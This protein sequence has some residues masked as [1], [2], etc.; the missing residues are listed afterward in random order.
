MLRP[1]AAAATGRPTEELY[2]RAGPLV[3]CERC[4]LVRQDP[5]ARVPYGDAEDPHYLTEIDGLRVTFRRTLSTIERFRLPPGRFLDVG[6]GPGVLVEE[7]A[8]RGWDAFGVELSAWSVNEAQ[9]RGTDVRMRT[10]EDLNE[11]AGSIDAAT[12]TD[13]IEHLPDPLGT[14][15]LLHELLK[16]GGVVFLA[17][18]DVGSVVARA[19]RRWWWSVLPGH[20]QLFSRETLQRLVRDAGF[21]VVDVSTH[22]KT[23]SADYYAGRLV[24]YGGAL[25]RGARAVARKVFGDRLVSPDFRDRVAVIARKSA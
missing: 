15:R 8:E 16:P 7:A 14:M 1:K 21:D 2:G 25:G 10:L 23:F 6:A 9:R 13:V 4:G 24:G 11:P 17:T 20:I 18:P 22:P 19:L 3:R 5:P 12:L